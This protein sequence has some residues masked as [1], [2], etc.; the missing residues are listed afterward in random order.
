MNS[1]TTATRRQNVPHT[2]MFVRMLLRAAVMRRGRAAS[3]LVAMVV[4]AAVATA[5]LNLYIDVQAKLRKEFR[6]YGANVVV[7]GH[8]GQQLSSD[9]LQ[10]VNSVIAGHGLPY[11]S[12]MW[13]R[14]PATANRSSSQEPISNKSRDWIAGGL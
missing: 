5:M 12:R 7:V 9:A 11:H 6:N 13:L 8:D 4:A 10:N 3:A 2:S 1:S 14:G